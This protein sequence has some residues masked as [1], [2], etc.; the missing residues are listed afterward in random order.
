MEWSLQAFTSMRGVRLFLRARAV[1]K[2]V[3]LAAS[4]LENT[5]GELRALRKFSRQNHLD[6]SS[7]KRFAPINLG[8]TV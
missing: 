8:D 4:T 6:L 3:L 5:D 2:F 7:K 1:I